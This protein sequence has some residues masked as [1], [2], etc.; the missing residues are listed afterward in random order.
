MGDPLAPM[1]ASNGKS[2]CSVKP[3]D[4]SSAYLPAFSLEHDQQTSIAKSY[5]RIRQ[6]LEPAD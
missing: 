5:P 3:K 1:L 4:T 2:L 6:L